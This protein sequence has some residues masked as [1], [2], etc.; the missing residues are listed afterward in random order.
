M[1]L[2]IPSAKG[3]CSEID[4]K[5]LRC[6]DIKTREHNALRI[7]SELKICSL[8]EFG[9]GNPALATNC[10]AFVGAGGATGATAGA[11]AA[12]SM[13]SIYFLSNEFITLPLS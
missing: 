3:L 10:W 12:A 4:V 8:L 7:K 9:F 6:Q 13:M 2:I 11:G 5:I 1:D